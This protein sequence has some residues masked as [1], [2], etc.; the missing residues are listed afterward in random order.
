[1][2]MSRCKNDTR[3][4]GDQ[5]R[6]FN[7]FK[8]NKISEL[9]EKESGADG[10]WMCG[11]FVRR[12]TYLR[13]LSRKKNQSTAQTAVESARPIHYSVSDSVRERYS[14]QHPPHA[15]APRSRIKAHYQ[16]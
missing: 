9:Q 13:N 6:Q 11:G 10:I 1:M 7:F 14:H 2:M 5:S 16:A 4:K 15:H 8:K 3:I 12:I